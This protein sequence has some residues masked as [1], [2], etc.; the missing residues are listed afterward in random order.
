MRLRPPTGVKALKDFMRRVDNFEAGYHEAT[1]TLICLLRPRE[2]RQLV[3]TTPSTF[4]RP[5]TSDKIGKGLT[6]V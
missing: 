5:H 6:S 2:N 1:A 3:P 4:G